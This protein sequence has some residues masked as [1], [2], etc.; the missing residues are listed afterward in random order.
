[1]R[2]N[3]PVEA[4]MKVNVRL[5]VLVLDLCKRSHSHSQGFGALDFVV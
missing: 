2:M 1:M 3:S 4:T 5:D